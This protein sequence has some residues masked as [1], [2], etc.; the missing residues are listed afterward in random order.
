MY[1]WSFLHPAPLAWWVFTQRDQ[2]NCH[3]NEQQESS[4]HHDAKE[5]LGPSW[6]SWATGQAEAV[7]HDFK[8]GMDLCFAPKFNWLLQPKHTII[9]WNVVCMGFWRLDNLHSKRRSHFHSFAY[10]RTP[11]WS[12]NCPCKRITDNGS[13]S[14][15]PTSFLAK[16]RNWFECVFPAFVMHTA[17]AHEIRRYWFDWTPVSRETHK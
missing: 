6:P 10:I 12:Q 1:I 4:S 17:F 5:D 7:T 15:P 8:H 16:R 3:P 11:I 14:T 2:H 13:Q 9:T